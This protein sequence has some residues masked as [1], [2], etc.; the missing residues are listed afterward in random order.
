MS[1]EYTISGHVSRLKIWSRRGKIDSENTYRRDEGMR[2][3]LD[4]VSDSFFL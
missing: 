2:V 3:Y 4:E 1:T